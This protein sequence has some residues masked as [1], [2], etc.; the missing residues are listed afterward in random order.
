MQDSQNWSIYHIYECDFSLYFCQQGHCDVNVVDSVD[1]SCPL[2]AA[3]CH[4]KLQLVD[5]LVK[6]GADVNL[7]N[8]FGMTSLQIAINV[9]GTRGQNMKEEPYMAEV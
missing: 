6:H 5:V 8:R 7:Q 4:D 3:I 9:H 2:V 1:G